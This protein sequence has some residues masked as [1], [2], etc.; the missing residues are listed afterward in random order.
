[1]ALWTGIK[2]RKEIEESW[3]FPL[4]F[5]LFLKVYAGGL[6]VQTCVCVCESGFHLGDPSFSR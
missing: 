5:F 6:I 2:E 3:Y 4:P 1:M